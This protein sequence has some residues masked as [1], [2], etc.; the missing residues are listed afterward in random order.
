VEGV[1]VRCYFGR[2]EDVVAVL[3]VSEVVVAEIRP[4]VSISATSL[5]LFWQENGIRKEKRDQHTQT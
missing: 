3:A 2:G 5:S 4:I 1:E